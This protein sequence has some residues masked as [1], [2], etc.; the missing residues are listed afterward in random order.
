MRVFVCL[1]V[2]TYGVVMRPCFYSVPFSE[3]DNIVFVAV[4][5]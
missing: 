2:C 4:L 5:D 3:L 1:C